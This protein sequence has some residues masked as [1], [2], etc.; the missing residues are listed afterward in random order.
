M[1]NLLRFF[2]KPEPVPTVTIPSPPK[3]TTFEFPPPP[4]NLDLHLE[5]FPVT[6]CPKCAGEYLDPLYVRAQGAHWRWFWMD[7]RDGRWEAGWDE[8]IEWRCPCGYSVN[9]AP[10]AGTA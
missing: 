8:H 10:D 3:A 6:R 9:S 5:P 7:P 4:E 2:R 1:T